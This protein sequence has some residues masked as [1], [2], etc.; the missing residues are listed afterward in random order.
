MPVTMTKP[1]QCT[2]EI[3]TWVPPSL[4]DRIERDAANEGRSLSNMA[5]RILENWAAEHSG[6]QV[7]Q[8][9]GA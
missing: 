1:E 7:Q 6:R 8:R 2:A 3:K 5:R 9:A 4:R